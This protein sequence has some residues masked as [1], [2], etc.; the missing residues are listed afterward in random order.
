MVLYI[1]FF[2]LWQLYIGFKITFWV[3][4]A[5]NYFPCF[6]GRI[7]PKPIIYNMIDNG[8]HSINFYKHENKIP[9][10][11][12]LGRKELK[13]NW[14]VQ[15]PLESTLKLITLILFEARIKHLMNTNVG[16]SD[17]LQL[18]QEP[19]YQRKIRVF[20]SKTNIIVFWVLS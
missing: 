10:I 14:T 15:A 12:N 1:L 19:N 17:E 7:Y 9:P 20:E 4:G 3:L 18:K 16:F 6:W 8:Y 5:K 11:S 13:L 2:N